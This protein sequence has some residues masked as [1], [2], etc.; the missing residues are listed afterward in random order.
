MLCKKFKE[1]GNEFSHAKRKQSQNVGYSAEQ[2]TLLSQ[3]TNDMK[4]RSRGLLQIKRL[5]RHNHM[6]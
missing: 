5:K 6:Q 1:Y 3:Q 2:T 4:Q